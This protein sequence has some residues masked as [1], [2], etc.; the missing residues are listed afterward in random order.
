[1][2][3]HGGQRPEL[4]TALDFLKQVVRAAV[5]SCTHEAVH[6]FLRVLKVGAW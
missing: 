3:P 4:T 6:T 2:V 1:M 5:R